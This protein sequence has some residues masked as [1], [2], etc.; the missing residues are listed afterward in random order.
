MNVSNSMQAI[1][2]YQKSKDYL[3]GSLC[4]VLCSTLVEFGSGVASHSIVSS[5]SS[6]PVADD[7]GSFCD[8]LNVGGKTAKLSFAR[9][10]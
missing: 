9:A 3:C 2:K 6:S 5:S 10:R 4:F 7:S 1:N 8:F